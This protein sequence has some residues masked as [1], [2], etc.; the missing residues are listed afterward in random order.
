MSSAIRLPIKNRAKQVVSYALIDAR[1]A[2]LLESTWS[3]TNGYVVRSVKTENGW[4]K[5]YLHRLVMGLTTE[6]AVLVD[7]KDGNKVNC[8][9]SNLRLATK[10]LNMQNTYGRRD[11]TYP[12]GV[13][14]DKRRGVFYARVTLNGR[15]R[16]LGTF[17]DVASADRAARAYRRRHMPYSPDAEAVSA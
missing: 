11:A 6:D 2:H 1:D 8:R 9:R 13:V 15:T 5:E 16:P 3:M 10:S 14:F 4:R 12:R 7:H 17:H